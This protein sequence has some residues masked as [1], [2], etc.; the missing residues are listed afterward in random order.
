MVEQVSRTTLTSTAKPEITKNI[1]EFTVV[2]E[3]PVG[4]AKNRLYES[5]YVKEV[6]ISVLTVNGKNYNLMGRVKYFNAL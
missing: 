2:L 5:S 4:N 1:S 6:A 3:R